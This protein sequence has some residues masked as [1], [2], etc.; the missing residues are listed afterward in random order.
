MHASPRSRV[1][2]VLAACAGAALAFA[3]GMWQAGLAA[4]REARHAR[5]EDANRGGPAGIGAGLVD[6]LAYDQR[7]VVVTGSFVPEATI[8]LDNRSYRGVPGLHV[9]TPLRLAD[10]GAVVI[11]R[12]WMPAPA[13]P[14]QAVVA[15]PAP[16]GVVK[17]EGVAVAQ[18]ASGMAL[19]GA[20]SGKLGGVWPNF[21]FAAYANATGLVLQPVILHQTS[22]APDGL[23]RDWPDTGAGSAKHRA[24]AIL[25]FAAALASLGFGL[26]PVY[27]ARRLRKE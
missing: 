16:A 3:L 14:N 5:V 18:V 25:W 23:V 21:S 9:L 2:P 13:R 4:E 10:G 24:Y 15:P 1:V 19:R 6:P 8:L 17:A 7:R 12:G 11:N 26:W 22:A 27:A 20:A